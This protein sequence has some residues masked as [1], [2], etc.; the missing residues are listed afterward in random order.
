MVSP[1]SAAFV[2]RHLAKEKMY[3]MFFLIL[4]GSIYSARP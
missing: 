4:L 3:L 2:E 1:E